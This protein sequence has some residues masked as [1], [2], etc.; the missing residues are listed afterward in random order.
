MAKTKTTVKIIFSDFIYGEFKINH[1]KIISRKPVLLP[2]ILYFYYMKLYNKKQYRHFSMKSIT[3]MK[4][5]MIK[6][7]LLDWNLQKHVDK[8]SGIIEEK[9][10]KDKSAEFPYSEIEHYVDD[11]GRRRTN[12][13]ENDFNYNWWFSL[14][15]IIPSRLYNFEKD[16]DSRF[17]PEIDHIFPFS[18][19]GYPPNF[20]PNTVWNFQPVKGD[21]N[22]FKLDTMPKE[23]FKKYPQYL[24]DYDFLPKLN[25]SKI[26]WDESHADQ[27]VNTRKQKIKKYLK[28][29]Y[30]LKL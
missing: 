8:F 13:T 17:N 1:E 15:I 22:N 20:E 21:I 27:F 9:C 7:Q 11:Q 2:L 24:K 23:F 14:K 12:L 6:S 28:T 29:E 30:N 25:N 26:S 3:N 4:K 18:G 5:F 10:Y 16:A 19:Q